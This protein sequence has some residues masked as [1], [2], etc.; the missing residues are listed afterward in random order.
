MFKTPKLL[1]C[2]QLPSNYSIM[3]LQPSKLWNCHHPRCRNCRVPNHNLLNNVLNLAICWE[4]LRPIGHGEL[5]GPKNPA[6]EFQIFVAV[7]F[8]KISQLTMPSI[9]QFYT[10][11]CIAKVNHM[12][13]KETFTESASNRKFSHDLI[14]KNLVS[15]MHP[16]KK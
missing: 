15:W 5:L 16:L 9:T 2:V 11:C 10:N 6:V 3:T 4:K 14:K 13:Q 1:K 7:G 12:L 8:S